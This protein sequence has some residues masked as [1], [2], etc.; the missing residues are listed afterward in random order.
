[1]ELDKDK[2]VP[3]KVPFETHYEHHVW[4]EGQI[5]AQKKRKSWFSDIYKHIAKTVIIVILGAIGSVFILGLETKL[6]NKIIEVNK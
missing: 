5:E 6:N 4:T 1:M 3:F 2:K